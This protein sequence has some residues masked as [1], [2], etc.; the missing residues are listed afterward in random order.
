MRR[1]AFL[2]IVAVAAGCS[3]S[4]NPT[5]PHSPVPNIQF[6]TGNHQTDSIFST[7]PLILKVKVNNPPHHQFAA[8]QPI[9]FEA[10]STY[11]NNV[12]AGIRPVGSSSNFAPALQDTTN[13]LAEVSVQVVLGFAVG[14]AHIVVTVPAFGYVDTAT[15]TVTPGRPYAMATAPRDTLVYIGTALTMRST[16][17]DQVNN[18]LNE[19]VSYS[20]AAGSATVSGAVVTPTALG[21]VSVVASSGALADTT[22]IT[23]VP[24]GTL[25]AMG[26]QGIQLYHLD[27][28]GASTVSPA[29]R[30]YATSDLKWSP[31]GTLLVFDQTFLGGG[32][33]M[34]S[35]GGIY[36][37]DLTG[38][39]TMIDSGASGSCDWF[40][41]Y[42][43]DGS[44]IY[45][46]RDD[47]YVSTLWRA[48]ADGSAT[49]SVPVAPLAVG[50]QFYVYP[51]ASP[52]GSQ[53]AF[54]A[55]VGNYTT[56]YDLR[57]ATIATGATR[58]LGV[59]GFS[60]TWSPTANQI[61]YIANGGLSGPIDLINADGTL[62]RT[63]ATGPYDYG[64]DWSPDGRYLVARNDS[65]GYLDVIDVTTGAR[66]SLPYS[67]SL[68][69]PTW[70]PTVP[71]GAGSPQMQRPRDRP[72]LRAGAQR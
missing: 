34:V 36:T 72:T 29:L 27:G 43:R 61:A 55:L 65:S 11:G 69:W 5:G 19:P 4:S 14:V 18:V 48:R 2:V 49:D 53:L 57:V 52:D 60:P 10:V 8:L 44:W 28:S 63:L 71:T 3:S 9:V 66:V 1:L 62:N 31:S 50:S 41:S 42:S 25:A 12:E 70:L 16:V 35:P 58:T 30:L 33:C 39:V 45:F 37:T 15:F 54:S 23:A 59:S 47:G 56:S 6:L 68:R 46:A 17:A 7:L 13:G 32:Q 26:G 21:T 24:H 22:S 20:I 40:A 64:M 67:G 51:S 38:A